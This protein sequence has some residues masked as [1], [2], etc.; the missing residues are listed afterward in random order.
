MPELPIWMLGAAFGILVAMLGMFWFGSLRRRRIAQEAGI[1]ALAS[2]KWRECVGLILQGLQKSGYREQPGLRLGGESGASEFVLLR[3]GEPVLFSYKHGTA[4]RLGEANVRDFA[5]AVQLQGAKSGLLVT[6]GSAEGFARSL[7]R[8]FGIEIMDGSQVWPL[9]DDLMPA[10]LLNRVRSQSARQT[11]LGLQLSAVI[12]L[13]IAGAS[14][15][16]GR[17]PDPPP[18]QPAPAAPVANA[19]APG[20]APEPANAAATPAASAASPP[21]PTDLARRQLLEAQQALRELEALTP[22]Q[23]AQ[24]RV[25]SATAVNQ[26]PQ[27]RNASWHSESTLVVVPAV[28]LPQDDAPLVN[29]I[30]SLLLR[31]E[32]QRYTRV[33]LEPVPGSGGSVRWRTCQ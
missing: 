16:L 11:R 31:Y 12:G 7:A 19:D 25:D 20:A 24:H 26:I 13:A 27:V 6:L 9:V 2:M 21:D 23:R 28:E 33:Q 29:Q 22:E 30:C 18:A 8:R 4:Y 32:E 15:W 3:D 14:Y 5:N 1:T 10:A 17:T